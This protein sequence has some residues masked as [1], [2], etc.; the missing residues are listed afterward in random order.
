[1][2]KA[3]AVSSIGS[4]LRSGYLLSDFGL[5]DANRLYLGER[6]GSVSGSGDVKDFGEGGVLLPL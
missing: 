2:D 6:R 5:S 4:C 1:M 3:T